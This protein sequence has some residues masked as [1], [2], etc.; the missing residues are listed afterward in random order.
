M[1]E[2]IHPNLQ[3]LEDDY[4]FIVKQPKYLGIA[5]NFRLNLGITYKKSEI[6]SN[7]NEILVHIHDELLTF[8]KPDHQR[9][10]NI[11][12]GN[13]NHRRYASYI[14]FGTSNVES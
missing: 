10:N 3:Y 13:K 4:H 8:S 1:C 12:V 11:I 9:I 5:I 6:S 2:K 14:L 7:Q